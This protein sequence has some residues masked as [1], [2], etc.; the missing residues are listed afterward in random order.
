LSYNKV[1]V[2]TEAEIAI[3][4]FVLT[5]IAAV[6]LIVLIPSLTLWLPRSLGF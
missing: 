4:C 6:A 3:P 1:T 2:N 5:H